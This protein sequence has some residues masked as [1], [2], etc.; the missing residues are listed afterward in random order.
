MFVKLNIVLPALSLIAA[1]FLAGVILERVI[2][3]KLNKIIK[4]T[5]WAG[6]K[7][8][9]GCIHGMVML[10]CVIAGA[11]A[12]LYNI[13]LNNTLFVLLQKSLVIITIFTVTIVAERIVVGFIN[14]YSRGAE[15][16]FPAISISSNITKIVIYII[17]LLVILQTLGISIAPILTALG[18]GGLAV[19]LALKDT[20]ANL[21]AGLHIL[22]SQQV[23][24]GDY[25]KLHSGEEGY[26]A[27]ITWRNTTIRTLSANIV[28]VPNANLAAAIITNFDLPEKDVS[29][30][31]QIGVSYGSDLE[32]VEKTA[33][34]VAVEVMSEMGAPGFEP[35]VRYQTFGDSSV[36]FSV[37]MRAR[38][39][40]GQ[41]VMAHEFIKRLHRRFRD[42]GIEIPFP[43]GRPL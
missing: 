23:K 8:I 19:A 40:A 9:I 22:L 10:W 27:D 11:H 31:V 33:L 41:A 34:A 30:R 39:F 28:I 20:L 42:E 4:K 5:D 37:F 43:L 32:K 13:P 17:G 21:F 36:I 25:I 2:F 35:S 7:I 16:I 1:G 6:G 3:A 29:V 38:E 14:L 15:G 26:V 12:A 18:V 24:P